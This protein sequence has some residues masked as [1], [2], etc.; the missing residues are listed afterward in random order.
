[1]FLQQVPRSWTRRSRFAP[2]NPANQLRE[3]RPA[4]APGEATALNYGQAIF[5]G[6]KA[7][8]PGAELVVSAPGKNPTRSRG[9]LLGAKP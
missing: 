1:M 9:V 2:K 4:L 7:Q 8:L 5:E 6:L 3:K